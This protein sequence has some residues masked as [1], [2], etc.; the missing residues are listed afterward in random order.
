MVIQLGT[1]FAEKQVLY[2][3]HRG[4]GT[5]IR[6]VSLAETL[7]GSQAIRDW[8]ANE[9][10]PEARRRG[11]AELEHYRSSFADHS[12]FFVIDQ[13]KNYYFNDA[14]NNFAGQQ[15]RYVVNED[16]P[17][18]A[19]YFATRSLGQGCHLN[20]DNDATLRVTKV[21][22][23][24][25][26]T[27][28]GQVV[29]ILGTG[30]DLSSFIHEVV[31]IPQVG[32]TSMFIDRQGLVQAHRDK[33]LVSLSSLSAAMRNKRT[34]FSLLDYEVDRV[35]LQTMM[36]KVASGT[37]LALSDFY[38]IDGKKMLLGVGYL[39]KLGWYNVTVMDVDAIINRRLFLPIA[40]LLIGVMGLV[41]FQLM[42][43]FKKAVLD[44]VVRL[45]RAV[46]QV[47]EGD[48]AAAKFVESSR[49][50]EIGRLA[51]S[52]SKMATAID[53]N[54]RLLETRVRER[55][56]ELE[57]IAFHDGLTGIL[58][59][60]GFTEV[61]ANTALCAE[62]GLLLID[63]DHFKLVND[64]YGHAAGDAV[65][66]ELARRLT[67]A[68][69]DS[70]F[71]GR[72][73]GDEFIVLLDAS[74]PSS[75]EKRTAEIW[76]SLGADAVDAGAGVAIEVSVSIGACKVGA[77]WTLEIAADAADRALYNAKRL[78]RNRAVIAENMHSLHR[79]DPSGKGGVFAGGIAS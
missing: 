76:A 35:R 2:D 74:E 8:A 18:D 36:D 49:R 52:F 34:V 37:T 14:S 30:I 42:I 33:N 70:D 6:E 9:D 45:E 19:W 21:W 66:Q 23:N 71:C 47:R 48:F 75:L 20:V 65:V 31:N 72:W 79:E 64:T 39:D 25:V 56:R 13:S 40:I 50:D 61:F 16:N 62:V 60:R 22:M 28:G 15:M 11:L 43:V 53:D 54:T 68:M 4:L 77:K 32:V 69:T 73:G 10:D 5:L 46:L 24:C 29:G 59:R 57:Q 12:Y 7:A 58:N 1:L 63:I 3:R 17:R 67:Q 78:G 38:S 51:S 55:T 27:E 26:V 44:R 41:S